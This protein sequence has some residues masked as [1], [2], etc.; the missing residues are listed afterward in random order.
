MQM[1]TRSMERFR[2]NPKD[3]RFIIETS[4]RGD[5]VGRT[6]RELF[7][8]QRDL[9]A[10]LHQR[11]RL[12]ELGEAVSKVNHDL[13]NIL[14]SAQLVSDQL[15][16]IEDPKVQR[17]GTKLFSA[18]DRAVDLCTDTLKYG[19]AEEAP[20]QFSRVRVR[21][22]VGDVV[23]LLSVSAAT[24]PSANVPDIRNEVDDDIVVDADPD[25]LYRALMNVVRNARDAHLVS[26][27][28]RG[29]VPFVR[30]RTEEEGGRLHI[31]VE[32]NGPGIPERAR[33]DLFKPF[34]GSA[35][36]GGSGLGLAIAREL[37]EVQGGLLQ[38][39]S[40]GD[41]G[42]VFQICLPVNPVAK[43]PDVGS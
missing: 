34:S 13:K 23:T 21:D 15:A 7:E 28:R 43:D 25:K 26:G 22:V 37:A 19:K 40:T 29:E 11:A 6:E 1:I 10:A 20:P 38:L 8:M 3:G 18:I 12:A 42:T 35:T 32:D 9:Q 36:S 31:L 5:E 16:L 17:L 24:V 41:E 27:G 4:S 39:I 33:A 30:I 14:T 2:Q